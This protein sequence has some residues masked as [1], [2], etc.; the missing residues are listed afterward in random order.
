MG[1]VLIKYNT[2]DLDIYPNYITNGK[3]LLNKVFNFIINCSGCEKIEPVKDSDSKGYHLIFYCNRDCEL[4]RLLFD[5][6]KRF[7][8]DYDRFEQ[9]KNVMFDDKH[10]KL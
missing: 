5:D 2:I 7:M 9:R 8:M 4:C 1:F 3:E 10:V 6:S